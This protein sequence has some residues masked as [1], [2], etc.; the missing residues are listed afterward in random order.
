[1]E[2]LL[3]P[4][5]AWLWLGIT[6]LLYLASVSLY[7]NGKPDLPLLIKPFALVVTVFGTFFNWVLNIVLGTLM[8]LELPKE[9]YFSA[10]VGRHKKHSSGWRNKLAMFFCGKL[11]NPFDQ[12]HCEKSIGV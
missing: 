2:Y 12:D 11:L 9:L 8:F 4:I 3:I 10:R 5:T 1:M 6:W 7:R